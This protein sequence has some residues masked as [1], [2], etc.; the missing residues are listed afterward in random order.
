V[1]CLNAPS[2]QHGVTVIAD[3]SSGMMPYLADV[4]HLLEEIEHV[5]GVGNT[6]VIWIGDEDTPPDPQH[7]PAQRT[8][9]LVLSTL[10][11][12]QQPELG[13]TTRRRWLEF[14]AIA[15]RDDLD[16]LALVPHRS[17]NW[18]DLISA[19]I[20]LVAWDDL[21]RAGRGRG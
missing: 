12:G 21:A 18:P 11:M 4:D 16:V 7:M 5:A 17:P 19:A 3:V 2:T 8:P 15:K 20:R 1:P 9:V 14:A 6:A 10:G 13:M